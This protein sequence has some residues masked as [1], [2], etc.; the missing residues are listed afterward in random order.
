MLRPKKRITK[1]QLKEDA[2]VSTYVK[3][4][5][6]YEKHKRQ[7]SIGITAI[8]VVAIVA[9][10]YFRN[11]ADSN[12]RAMAQMAAV[13][14]FFD[15]GQYQ[16]AVDGAPERNIAGLRSIVDN[17]GGSDGGELARFYLANAYYNLDSTELALGC[18]ED[19]SPGNR[20]L[21]VS[22]Y[23]GIAACHEAL[24]NHLAAAE[25]FE[26]AASIDAEGVNVA[27]NL[28]HAARNYAESGEKEKAVELYLRL[29]KNHPTT[30]FG[31][32]ADRFISELS[33]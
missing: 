1:R 16:I 23:S 10:I 27:E 31:R 2:L 24:G 12:E 5:T 18:F 4:T 14:A 17:Y 32:E 13:Y 28:H 21:A 19:F 25:Y 20:F 11:R 15:N 33:V 7:I 30:R 26:R 29:K 6:F 3:V 9:L 22:R 8:V